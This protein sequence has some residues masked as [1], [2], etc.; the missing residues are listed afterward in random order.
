VKED[1]EL[2]ESKNEVDPEQWK[3]HGGVLVFAR[4]PAGQ[5]FEVCLDTK[6]NV[7]GLKGNASGEVDLHLHYGMH[8]LL[9]VKP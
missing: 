1:F 5:E 3:H 4:A 6:P 8:C 7:L 2:Y 9:L